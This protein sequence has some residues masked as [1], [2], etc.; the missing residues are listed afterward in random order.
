MGGIFQAER[1][2][3]SGQADGLERQ[4]HPQ[5]VE[6]ERRN[7]SK[8]MTLFLVLALQACSILGIGGDRPRFKVQLGGRMT[9][10]TPSDELVRANN[11]P[12]D[13]RGMAGIEVEVSGIDGLTRTLTG[14]DFQKSPSREWETTLPDPSQIGFVVRLR[15]S[16]RQLLA[17]EISGSFSVRPQ[18]TWLWR[19]RLDR[20]PRPFKRNAETGELLCPDPYWRCLEQ[21]LVEIREDGRNYPSEVLRI[22]L[23]RSY[24]RVS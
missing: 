9:Y 8:R 5:D 19:L 15:D 22:V 3:P 1:K 18:D 7:M 10:R 21:W 24:R 14:A 2:G 23:Y 20:L 13:P 11:S 12:Q 17:E 4:R 6:E 16:E